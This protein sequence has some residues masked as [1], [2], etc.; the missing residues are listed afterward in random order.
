MCIASEAG[1]TA[2]RISLGSGPWRALVRTLLE[3]VRLRKM[4]E[5]LILRSVQSSTGA[6]EEESGVVRRWRAGDGRKRIERT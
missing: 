6:T 5:E 1:K 4:M 2:R 3:G